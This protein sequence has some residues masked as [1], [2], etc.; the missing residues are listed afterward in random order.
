LSAYW[1]IGAQLCPACVF[2]TLATV[3]YRAVYAR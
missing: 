3:T 2:I 1:P